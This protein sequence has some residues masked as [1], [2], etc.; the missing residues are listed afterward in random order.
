[1]PSRLRAL[2]AAAFGFALAACN[3]GLPTAPSGPTV[4]ELGGSIRINGGSGTE[5]VFQLEVPEGVGKLRLLLTGFNGDADL[6]VRFG[7]RPEPQ[8]VDCASESAYPVEEC[9]FDAPSAGVWYVLV[10]GYSNYS[11]AD[12]SADAFPQVG[13][14]ELS[15]GVA[16][17]G[18]SGEPGDFEMFFITVPSG[19]DSLVVDLTSTGDPDLY[20][21]FDRYPL[22][23]DYECASF[24]PTGIEHCVVVNPPAGRWVVRVDSYFA[25]TD[26]TLTPRFYAAPE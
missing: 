14:A 4:L 11:N 12:L 19:L 16:V 18:L 8:N 1:M 17:T 10:Y 25:F 6:Y 20:L 15:D 9:I 26:G 5:R 7:A 23:N 2:L 22:L 13:E 24:T 3:E 21:G